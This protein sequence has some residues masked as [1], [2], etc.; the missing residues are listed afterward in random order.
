MADD[1]KLQGIHNILGECFETICER[2]ENDE[3]KKF[4]ICRIFRADY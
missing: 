2:S 1:W 4:A 3:A